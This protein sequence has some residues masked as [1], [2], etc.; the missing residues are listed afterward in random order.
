[1]KSEKSMFFSGI[2]VISVISDAVTVIRTTTKR[3]FPLKNLKRYFY[4]TRI[5]AESIITEDI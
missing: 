4:S 5:F 1:M 2:F 3:S